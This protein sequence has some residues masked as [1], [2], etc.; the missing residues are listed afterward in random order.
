MIYPLA[1]LVF[2]AVTGALRA[3]ARGG[4]PA[5]LLQWAVVHAIIFGLIGLFILVGIERSYR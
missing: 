1:G 4:K 3:R 5:D 2:G